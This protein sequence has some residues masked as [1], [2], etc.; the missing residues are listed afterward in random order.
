M[1]PSIQKVKKLDNSRGK[2]LVAVSILRYFA[3]V[4]FIEILTQSAIL[5]ICLQK[6]LFMEKKRAV[7]RSNS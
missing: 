2:Y 1:A 6:K 7:I 5:C 3:G 4:A